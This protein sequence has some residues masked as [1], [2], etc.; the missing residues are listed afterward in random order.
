MNLGEKK[1]SLNNIFQ[2]AELS[3]NNKYGTF[4]RYMDRE[5]H[6][7]VTNISDFKDFDLNKFQEA[8]QKVFEETDYKVHYDKMIK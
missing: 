1:D 7:D 6:S 3:D 8:F 4:K 5:S 2:K